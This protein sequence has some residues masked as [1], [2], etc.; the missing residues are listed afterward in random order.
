MRARTDMVNHS[1]RFGDDGNLY[2]LTYGESYDKLNRGVEDREESP[3]MPMQVDVLDPGTHEILR[4]IAVDP[5]VRAF[6]LLGTDRLAYIH[7]D[8]EGELVFKCVDISR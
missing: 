8:A 5:S 1:S 4:T 7:E 3:P 2:I 6:T